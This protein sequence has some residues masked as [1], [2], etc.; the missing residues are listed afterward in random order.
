VSHSIDI[1]RDDPRRLL[2]NLYGLGSAA[3]TVG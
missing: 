3:G 2:Y 1:D